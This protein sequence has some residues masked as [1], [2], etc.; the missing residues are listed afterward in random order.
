MK[1]TQFAVLVSHKEGLKKQMN[2]AQI[3][4]VMAVINEYT[5]GLLYVIIRWL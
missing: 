5:R 4:E 2:I 1:I 3:K